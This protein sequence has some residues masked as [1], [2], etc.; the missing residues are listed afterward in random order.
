MLLIKITSKDVIK[1]VGKKK[2]QAILIS[3]KNAQ[4][5]YN[6]VLQYIWL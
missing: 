6:K 5:F 4:F 3:V 1:T 2:K